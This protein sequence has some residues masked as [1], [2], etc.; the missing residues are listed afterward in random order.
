MHNN[1]AKRLIFVKSSIFNNWAR[2]LKILICYECYAQT[3]DG[4]YHIS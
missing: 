2:S 3:I 1:T 4:I